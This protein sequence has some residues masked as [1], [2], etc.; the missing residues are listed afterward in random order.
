MCENL[1]KLD[2]HFASV[3]T[4]QCPAKALLHI[5]SSRIVKFKHNH[6]HSMMMR[7]PVRAGA[8]TAGTEEKVGIQQQQQGHTA[9]TRTIL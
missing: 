8:E 6:L 9:T 7:A 4:T 5:E 2:H 3:S 1:R